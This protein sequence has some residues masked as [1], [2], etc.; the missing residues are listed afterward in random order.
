MEKMKSI[1][2][3]ESGYK[4]FLI[5]II[6]TGLGYGLYKGVLDN[7]FA[8]VV[9]LTEF[10][11]GVS[12]FFRELP[13]LALVFLLAAMYMFSAEG[14]Y[15]IGAVIMFG[16][17]MMQ[18][19][20]PPS[21]VLVIMAVCVYSLGEHI[22]LGMKSTLAMGYSHAGQEGKA[23]GMLSSA[24]Q[25]G[26]LIGYAV[27]VALFAILATSQI[28]YRSVFAGAAIFTGIGAFT[29]LK[30][31]GKSETDANNRRFYF[32]KKYTKFYFLEVFYGARKQVFLTFGPYALILIYGASTSL[33][34]TLYAVSAIC[35]FFAAPLVGK[36]I[37]RIGYKIVMVSDTIILVF[38]CLCYG[39]AHRLF[40][41]D[42]ALIICCVNYLLDAVI[43]LAS[44]ASNVYVRDLSDNQ[45][46][47]RAT[48]STGISV[49][50][51]I[52]ILI[53]LFG[54]WIWKAL[55]IEMLF[56]LSAIL[57]LANSAYAASIKTN[58][59]KINS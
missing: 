18:A 22:Q 51:L 26:N 56:I 14:L 35:C 31:S 37:D 54:G 52:S 38:V 45:E 19:V 6:A 33:I 16:G 3:Q 55:G 53:A 28:L 43:S 1:F 42:I 59:K 11:R 48:L 17:L 44:M 2:R 20:I 13:G 49:N 47:L 30:L 25:I 9:K 50:H 46:E 8:E 34:S 40:P 12:E 27:I 36:I 21:R 23:L 5:S 24:A 15:K 32:H 29:A 10:D 41:K 58:R 57:G 39:F 4:M 7:Y